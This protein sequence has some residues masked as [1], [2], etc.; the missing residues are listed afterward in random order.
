MNPL[1][2]RR[3][4]DLAKLTRLGERSRGRIVISDIKGQ[5]LDEAV[6]TLAYKTVP[7]PRYP[8][9]VRD[10]TRVRVILS[11][12][13]PFQEP[14]IEALDPVFNPNIYTSGRFCLG[15]KWL[16]TENL[17]L[18]IT[19]VIKI[20]TFNPEILSDRSPAN[21]EAA[22]WY[23]ATASTYPSAFPTDSFDLE[24]DVVQKKTLKW[25][26]VTSAEQG[27]PAAND[28][29]SARCPSCGAKLRLYDSGTIRCPECEAVFEASR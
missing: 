29:A 20:L 8:Q 27:R 24:P 3:R 16:A 22:Q 21:M 4:Q 1:D 28:E 14:A 26:E 7:S 6:I 19:R 25:G 15:A 11:A 2:E 18:L 12:R 17:D 5:P 13:Y 23:N 10:A 9:E